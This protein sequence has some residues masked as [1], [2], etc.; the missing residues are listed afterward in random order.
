MNVKYVAKELEWTETMRECVEH[1]IV[2]PLQKFLDTDNFDLSVH[3]TMDR[4]R[5][6][7]RK[8]QFE[9]W[10]VLQT[11]DGRKNEIIRRHGSD[12]YAL[13]GEVSSGMRARVRKTHSVRAKPEHTLWTVLTESPA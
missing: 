8:P 11:Y 2:Q 5:V 3:L 7:Q 6:Q 10:V 12:F 13:V 4:K 1:K 9:M